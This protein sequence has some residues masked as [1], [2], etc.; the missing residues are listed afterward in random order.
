MKYCIKCG[1]ETD[2]KLTTNYRLPGIPVCHQCS[3]DIKRMFKLLLKGKIRFEEFELW[4]D[5]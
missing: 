3:G 1:T 2:I 5:G 4:L